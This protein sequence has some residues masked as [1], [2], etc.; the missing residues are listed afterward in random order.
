MKRKRIT[1]LCTTEINLFI[2][3][4]LT[5]K[6]CHTCCFVSQISDTR[7]VFWRNFGT[8]TQICHGVPAAVSCFHP[9]S[10]FPWAVSLWEYKDRAHHSYSSNYAH[11]KHK[12]PWVK[13]FFSCRE[14][15]CGTATIVSNWTDCSQHK[16]CRAAREC[17]FINIEII[18]IMFHYVS[19][20]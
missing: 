7:R 20:K 10:E 17:S 1:K 14:R 8:T 13:S 15:S 19:L 3:I 5:T 9:I 6:A 2:I 18:T 16:I 4:K 11:T 12:L